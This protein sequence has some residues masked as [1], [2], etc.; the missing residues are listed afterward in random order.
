[1]LLHGIEEV[2]LLDVTPLEVSTV[3]ASTNNIQEGQITRRESLVAPAFAISF[4]E[5]LIKTR[6]EL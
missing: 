5:C 1:M 3:P 6:A 4:W 2:P